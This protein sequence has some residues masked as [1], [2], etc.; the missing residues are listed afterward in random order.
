MTQ[1]KILNGNLSNSQH[2]KSKYG[3]KKGAVVTLIL[4]S[5]VVGDSNNENNFLHKS[6]LTNTQVSKLH[7]TFGKWFSS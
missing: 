3:M 6:I 5:N 7:K 2:N 1:Y 4:S